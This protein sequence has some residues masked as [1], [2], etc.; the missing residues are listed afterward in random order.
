MSLDAVVDFINEGDVYLQSRDVDVGSEGPTLPVFF[1]ETVG[2]KIAIAY[3]SSDLSYSVNVS[4]VFERIELPDGGWVLRID[5]PTRPYASNSLELRKSSGADKANWLTLFTAVE[6]ADDQIKS[7]LRAKAVAAPSYEPEDPS[8]HKIFK[9]LTV[10]TMGSGF[11]EEPIG[12]L[13]E[14]SVGDVVKLAFDE[15]SSSSLGRFANMSRLDGAAERAGHNLMAGSIRPTRGLNADDAAQ[16][17]LYEL[18]KAYYIQTG[19]SAYT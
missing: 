9:H 6:D 13:V 3:K 7:E 17:A 15:D 11:V 16:R 4:H 19:K 1:A 8:A 14:Q 5:N 12:V 10:S 18:A 2:S